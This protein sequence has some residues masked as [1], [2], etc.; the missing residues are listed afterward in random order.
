MEALVKHLIEY[1]KTRERGRPHKCD[2]SCDNTCQQHSSVYKLSPR[3]SGVSSNCTTA[4]ATITTDTSTQCKNTH[5]QIMSALQQKS[6]QIT[7]RSITSQGNCNVM[8]Q[9][10]KD[11]SCS[12]EMTVTPYIVNLGQ[13]VVV[14]GHH[15][16]RQI[17]VTVTSNGCQG[18]QIS[19]L[20]PHS[21]NSTLPHTVPHQQHISPI[22]YVPPHFP[23]QHGGKGQT[24]HL[25]SNNSMLKEHCNDMSISLD[26]S[27][28][29][30]DKL[31]LVPHLQSVTADDVQNV[32]RSHVDQEIK[33]GLSDIDQSKNDI[34]SSLTGSLGT[35]FNFDILDLLEIQEDKTNPAV[36]NESHVNSFN[37]GMAGSIPVLNCAN[38]LSNSQQQQQ[39]VNHSQFC[40]SN[41]NQNSVLHP[42]YHQHLRSD[43][44]K[45]SQQTE[46]INIVSALNT[47]Y[48][49]NSNNQGY[50]ISEFCPEWSFTEVSSTTLTFSTSVAV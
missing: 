26:D 5:E 48:N 12:Q 21:P 15:D 18:Q 3:G 17:D 31:N 29:N 28:T 30:K 35:D 7:L 38:C 6:Q 42:G 32:I 50:A 2:K 8:T 22:T 11:L 25:C 46:P 14:N 4:T 16:P 27:D 13:Y 40:Q 36:N 43:I 49:K 9:Q 1:H 47:Q 23:Q 41:S 37:G 24:T 33:D 44:Q 19:H 10:K 39:Q 34:D 20:I 45:T